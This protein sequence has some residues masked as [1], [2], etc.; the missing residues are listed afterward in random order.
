[1]M[2]PEVMESVLETLEDDW[3]AQPG[4]VN[5]ITCSVTMRYDTTPGEPLIERFTNHQ[6]SKSPKLA[7]LWAAK[8]KTSCEFAVKN[9][10]P[11]L[12]RHQRLEEVFHYQSL[13][14]LIGRLGS[15]AGR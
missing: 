2:S 11:A 7:G 5:G 15:G 3:A 6:P 4:F 13:P 12:K 9:V 8:V 1:M 10:H 14:D